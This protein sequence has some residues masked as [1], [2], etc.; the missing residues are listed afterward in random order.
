MKFTIA[1]GGPLDTKEFDRREF[2]TWRTAHSHAMSDVNYA[3]NKRSAFAIVDADTHEPA[4][5]EVKQD[6]SVPEFL[7]TKMP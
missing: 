1:W 7:P 4:E 5:G 3:S 6:H 2:N